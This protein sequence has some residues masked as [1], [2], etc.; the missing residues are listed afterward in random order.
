MTSVFKRQTEAAGSKWTES[1]QKPQACSWALSPCFQWRLELS[2]SFLVFFWGEQFVIMQWLLS[3]CVCV[4]VE[5][6]QVLAGPGTPKSTKHYGSFPAGPP[7]LV[8]VHGW[9]DLKWL[10]PLITPCIFKNLAWVWVRKVSAFACSTF[11]EQWRTHLLVFA[12]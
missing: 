8:S 2:H 3:E 1:N 11:S 10:S 12:T 5:Q 4:L 6:G 9:V 7:T